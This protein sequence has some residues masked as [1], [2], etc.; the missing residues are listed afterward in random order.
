MESDVRIAWLRSAFLRRLPVADESECWPWQGPINAGGYGTFNC[1]SVHTRAHRIAWLVTVGPIGPDDVVDHECHNRD[2]TCLGGSNCLHR[3]CVNPA[4][5]RITTRLENLR[6]GRHAAIVAAA[7]RTTCPKGH[8][9]D[10]ANTYHRPD[11]PH[12]RDCRICRAGAEAARRQ[13]IGNLCMVCSA[14]ISPRAKH[15]AE[16]RRSRWDKG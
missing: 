4:H 10:E 12:T 2:L 6:A 8:P 7:R 5:L 1:G 13:R 3:R 15:C 14:P 16:H 11:K 9:Y